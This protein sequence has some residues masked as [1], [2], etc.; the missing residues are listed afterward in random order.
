M[1]KKKV[2]KQIRRISFLQYKSKSYFRADHVTNESEKAVS[3]IYTSAFL[4]CFLSASGRAGQQKR[5]PKNLF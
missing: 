1:I 2:N 4:L 3:N 5:H